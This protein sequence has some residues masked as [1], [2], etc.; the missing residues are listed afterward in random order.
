MQCIG[1]VTNVQK[2]EVVSGVF[3][4]FAHNDFR[5]KSDAGSL[6]GLG[7][8]EN[9]KVENIEE[10]NMPNENLLENALGCMCLHV[11][12]QDKNYFLCRGGAMLH[13]P[14]FSFTLFDV[15]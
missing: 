4:T 12:V 9:E 11:Y 1:S 3:I 8:C 15:S 2:R 14:Q 10:E 7:D 5:W 13:S 6:Q